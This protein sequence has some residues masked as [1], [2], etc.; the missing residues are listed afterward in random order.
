MSWE[1]SRP[2]VLL[3]LRQVQGPEVWSA[4][5]GDLPLGRL[6]QALAQ[7]WPLNDGN[8]YVNVPCA[9]KRVI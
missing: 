2:E 4:A 7:A 8:D 1:P 3:P 9:L 6:L 5:S